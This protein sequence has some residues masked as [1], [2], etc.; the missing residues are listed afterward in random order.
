MNDIAAALILVGL[1]GVGLTVLAIRAADR[2]AKRH[3]VAGIE[4]L[5]IQAPKRKRKVRNDRA[6]Q[7]RRSARRKRAS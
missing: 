5:K 3:R 7:S 6:A 1:V 4:P 2:H